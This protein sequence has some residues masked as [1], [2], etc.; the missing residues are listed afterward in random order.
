MFLCC[1][2][3][4]DTI[5]SVSGVWAVWGFVAF[6]CL[7]FPLILARCFGWLSE[8]TAILSLI[9]LQETKTSYY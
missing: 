4:E 1:D 9:V 2:W 6:F 7:F 8:E 3:D 5:S